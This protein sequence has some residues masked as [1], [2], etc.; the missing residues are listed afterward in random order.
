MMSFIKIFHNSDLMLTEGALVERLKTEFR[1]KMDD[2]INH[3]G[4][5]YEESLILEQLYRQYLDIGRKDNLPIMIMT[6][7]RMFSAEISLR[8]LSI[9]ISVCNSTEFG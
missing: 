5:I 6:P 4:F 7:T 2:H 1:L 3:A 9:V 8:I